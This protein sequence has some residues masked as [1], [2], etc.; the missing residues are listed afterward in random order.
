M[1]EDKQREQVNFNEQESPGWEN[2]RLMKAPMTVYTPESELRHPKKLF[3]E[4]K[5]DLGCSLGLA[6]RLAV[7]DL[8]ALYRQTFLGYLW[9][10]LPPL[11]TSLTF[12]LLN[13][14]KIFEIRGIEI[15]YP[16]FVMTGTV[17]W[18]LFV[19]AL[20]APLRIVSANRGMLSKINFPKEALILSGVVQV[21]FSF[22][23]KLG[24]LAATI[25]VFSVPMKETAAL[26]PIMVMGFLVLGT[27]VGILLVPIGVLYQDVQQALTILISL[28]IFFTPVI[29]LPP[30]KG[31][32]ATLFKFNPL[33]PLFMMTRE[34]L[35][36][37]ETRYLS[38]SLMVTGLACFLLIL[39]WVIYRI[40]LP[41][42]IERME[43]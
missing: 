33:T 31:I 10:I 7:R 17:F 5:R 32:M 38:V 30:E 11:A 14:T 13:H 35:F 42:L 9:A 22:L 16:V 2:K 29:Y 18:Q 21:L 37:G 15:P 24:L 6:W 8:S 41:V 26:V 1:G 36:T 25:F 19:D 28:F 3:R 40:S 4:M 20:N 34:A 27:L 12:I 23:I 43:A 39:G